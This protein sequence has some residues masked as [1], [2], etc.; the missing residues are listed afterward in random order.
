M[1]RR[2]VTP[3][4]GVRPPA[5]LVVGSANMDLMARCPHIPAPGEI[6]LGSSFRSTSGGKGAN[7]A[8]AATRLI[9]GTAQGGVALLGAVGRDAHGVALRDNLHAR[10]VDIFS[11]WRPCRRAWR[12]S[13][14]RGRR[15]EQYRSGPGGE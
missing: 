11:R 4:P 13:S 12:L 7:G 5:I 8:T 6:I 15:G 2:D 9:A 3:F 10:G 14:C 1:D